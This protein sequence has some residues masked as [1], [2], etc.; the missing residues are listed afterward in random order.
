MVLEFKEVS[1]CNFPESIN[2][3]SE[4]KLKNRVGRQKVR[5][6]LVE[7]NIPTSAKSY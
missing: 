1:D 5:N 3:Q 6:K 2:K 7:I 4:N